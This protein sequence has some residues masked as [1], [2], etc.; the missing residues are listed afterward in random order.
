MVPPGI[1]RPEHMVTRATRPA[2][3]GH[4][5]NPKTFLQAYGSIIPG[6]VYHT[7]AGTPFTAEAGI[8][9]RGRRAG[10]MVIIFRRG[11]SE[12][13]RVYECCWG[14]R[15]NDN[16]TYIDAYTPHL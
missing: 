15:T 13:S 2:H 14:Y 6:H 10:E 7:A 9:T 16:R 8:V 11:R 12:R 3:F 1:R 5:I 4:V